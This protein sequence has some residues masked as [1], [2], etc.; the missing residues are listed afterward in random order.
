MRIGLFTHST[1]RRGGVVHALA[2]ARF[3]RARGHDVRVVAPDTRDD[4]EILVVP[5]TSGATLAETVAR[6]IADVRAFF[7]LRSAPRFDIW[8]AQ[9]PITANALAGLR[10][11]GVL[12]RFARTVHHL[13]TW[14]DPRLRHWQDEG[15]RQADRV[16][17]VSRHW[18]SRI[19]AAYDVAAPVVGNGVDL[20]RFRPDPDASDV[21]LAARLGLQRGE[22]G[23]VFA[24]FG[25]VE[26]R[27]NT[28]RVV[29]AFLRFRIDHPTARL[30]IAGGASL[31]D[32]SG[33]RARVQAL[34]EAGDAAA[35]VILLGP[36]PD[37]EVPAL[38]RLADAVLQ[39][40]R[41]EGFGLCPLEAMACG[42]PVV[43]SAIAPFDEHVAPHEAVWADPGDIVS[44]ENAL[45]LAVQ[46]GTARLLASSGPA[47]ASRFSWAAV[48]EAHL[49][50]YAALLQQNVVAHA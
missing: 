30:V 35:A 13:D 24:A 45:R 12:S 37:A 8:H 31:L 25:G 1:N 48:A 32:H 7:R 33:E 49:P 29:E 5:S 3:L 50:F 47:T 40:S 16:F 46:P 4:P 34:R 43:L 42:R 15:V 19:E 39:V 26:A 36:L 14:D 9:D 44:I 20:D 6:R 10:R 22:A 28:A 11:E 23:P 18:Q 21:A 41:A 2:L 38:Y 17:S 27:K